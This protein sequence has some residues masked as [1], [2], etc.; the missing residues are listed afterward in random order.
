MLLL[1]QQKSRARRTK[2]EA[3]S[4]QQASIKPEF[5]AHTATIMD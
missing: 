3:A 2:G 1:T 4:Q 5:P